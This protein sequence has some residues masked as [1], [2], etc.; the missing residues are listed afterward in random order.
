M[1][2]VLAWPR[3]RVGVHNFIRMI[4]ALQFLPISH[5]RH[6]FGKMAETATTDVTRALIPYMQRQ[7]MENS[8]FRV[9]DWS[10]FRQNIHTNNDAEGLY[11]Y[12]NYKKTK[13]KNI[14]LNLF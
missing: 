14:K 7:W 11:C 3:R 6:A 9:E 13:K 8:V 2:R 5:I 4:L 12:F 1:S 10:V